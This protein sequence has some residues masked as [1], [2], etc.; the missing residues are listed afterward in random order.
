MKSFS[1]VASLHP[2][3]M[4][5]GRGG[6]LPWAIKEDMAFFKQLTSLAQ[7]N[8]I[9]AVIMGRKTWESLPSKFR[10]LPGRKN[11]VLSKDPNIRE[12]L[13]IP[14]SVMTAVS[15]HHA[16]Q[17][18]SS[19]EHEKIDKIFVIGGECLYKEAI[20]SKYCSNIYITEVT[21][22]VDGFDTFF[23]TIPANRYQLVYRL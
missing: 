16:M 13:S 1:V 12:S 17:T 15:L 6:Q 20:Q 19:N 8:C 5:I 14:A 10:P 9:N 4:G 22:N 21:G 11:V 18:L 23:P 7:P 2:L 3:T